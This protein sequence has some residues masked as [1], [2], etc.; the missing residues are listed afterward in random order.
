[1]LSTPKSQFALVGSSLAFTQ[2]AWQQLQALPVVLCD[3][4]HS[5]YYLVVS[6][7]SVMHSSCGRRQVS[8]GRVC[9]QL[10][11]TVGGG[12]CLQYSNVG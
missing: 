3:L 7:S 9:Q 8:V 2:Q 11:R 1:M 4:E 12:R 5:S 6:S 10:I